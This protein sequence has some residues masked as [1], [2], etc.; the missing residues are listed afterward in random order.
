M[1]QEYLSNGAFVG[2]I[3]RDS[4]FVKVLFYPPAVD[5]DFGIQNFGKKMFA[6]CGGGYHF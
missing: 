4:E 2:M 5:F 6:E 1:G 3:A